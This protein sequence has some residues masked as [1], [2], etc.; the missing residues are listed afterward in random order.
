MLNNYNSSQP[1]SQSRQDL[2]DCCPPASD[3]GRQTWKALIFVAIVAAAGVVLAHSLVKKS[4]AMA[5]AALWG[6]ELD[7]LA[8][9]DEVA[10]EVDAVFILIAGKNQQDAQTLVG[11]IEAATKNIR[12]RGNQISAF[13]LKEDAADYENMAEQFSVPTVMAMVKGLGYSAVSGQI[14]EANLLDAFTTALQAPAGCCPP[15]TD[16]SV[17]DTMGCGPSDPK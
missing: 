6:P 16:P 3:R 17:C 13:R 5:E 7:S 12:S 10:T 8:S 1:E 15:G 9:L 11:E 2:Q 4:D 14:T